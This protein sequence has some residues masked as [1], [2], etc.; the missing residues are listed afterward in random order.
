MSDR[1]E[2]EREAARLE[3]EAARRAA[4]EARAA[5]APADAPVAP[6]IIDDDFDHPPAQPGAA[7]M[8][9]RPVTIPRPRRRHGL[10]IAIAAL[11]ALVLVVGLYLANGIFTPLKGDGTGRVVVR[12]PGGSSAR[13]IGNLLAENGVV[14]SGFFFSLRAGIAGK[15]NALR[16]GT[17]TLRHDMSNGA[18][19]TALTTAPPAAP[20][21]RVTLP[22]GPGR[23]QFAVRARA[24]G[25][26]GDYVAA[27]VRSPLLNPRSYGAPKGTSSLEGFLYPATYE[28]PR[29]ASARR[30]VRDQLKAF[31]DA[32]AQVD[33]R[34]ARKKNLTP[35]D[36]LTLA[37]IIEREV[38]LPRDRR[39]V[40]A[41]FYN[42]LKAGVALGSDATTLYAVNNFSRPLR[43]SELNS[44]SP[45]NTRK[46]PG[47]PPGPIG[48]PGLG[49]IEAAANPLA[50]KDFFFIVKPCGNG[51]LSFAT[52]DAGF[53]KLVAAYDAKRAQLGGKDPS[54][55]P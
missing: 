29:G 37:S 34:R 17:F 11:L 3:R 54:R 46:N 20:T 36:V 7:G 44:D 28:L 41:V 53:Q 33:L 30:L 4:D 42:R 45:Y 51:A 12:V 23:R 15:R 6:A 2:A 24:Q 52:T 19:L 10:R 55:C 39:R 43:V 49:S 21:I 38:F 26:T 27:S 5:Q 32:F 50:T 48:N 47:L 9:H 35:Y 40:A 18:A 1:S 22:E 8:P 14:D 13:A 31:K 25:V 16:S